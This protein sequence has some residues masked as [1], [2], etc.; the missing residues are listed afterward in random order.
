MGHTAT[1]KFSIAMVARVECSHGWDVCPDCDRCDCG[2]LER[3]Q[4]VLDKAASLLESTQGG[5]PTTGGSLLDGVRFEG[6]PRHE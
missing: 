6:G 1:C 5:G 2:D 4:R 3:T